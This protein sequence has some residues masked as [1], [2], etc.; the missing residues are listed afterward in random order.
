MNE[1][2]S[3]LSNAYDLQKEKISTL[4]D[5]IKD[6]LSAETKSN[7]ATQK[8]IS[9]V[10]QA[11]SSW[12]I[13][14]GKLNIVLGSYNKLTSVAKAATGAVVAS[15]SKIGSVMTVAFGTVLGTALNGA[16]GS[17]QGFVQSG[18][19]AYTS[20]ERLNASLK[21]LVA[22]EYRTKDPTLSMTDALSKA[23]VESEKLIGW[24]QQLA[25]DSPFSQEGV[26]NAF[27]MAKALGFNIDESKRLT[28]T[29]VD[30][31]SA[32]GKSE[33]AMQRIALALGQIHA[34]GKLAGGEMMQLT[35]A[36]LP[37]TEILA[38]AFHK[39]TQQI[40]QMQEDGL[41]PAQDAIA[42]LADSLDNDFGG[43]AKRQ[44][45]T[46]TGLLNSLQDLTTVNIREFFT[47]TFEAIQPYLIDFV[48]LM[49]DPGITASIKEIGNAMGSVLGAAMGFL[50]NTAIPGLIEGFQMITPAI[51]EALAYII[52]FS[53]DAYSWGSDLMDQYGNGII[54]AAGAVLD[55]IMSIASTIMNWMMPNS[56]PKFLPHIDDW[57][58]E[59]AQLYFDS[60]GDADFKAIDD[61]GKRVEDALS[62]MKASGDLGKDFN[63]ASAVLGSREAMIAATMEF[64]RFGSVTQSTLQRIRNTGGPVGDMMADYAKSLFQA[65]AASEQ[66]DRAQENLNKVTGQYDE[67]L[68]AIDNR[69]KALQG[70]QDDKTADKRIAAIKHQMENAA[71]LPANLRPD[72]EKLQNELEQLQLEKDR[73]AVE[74][75]KNTAVAIAQVQVDAAQKNS[76]I[77]N[78][79]LE[80]RKNLLDAQQSQIDLIKQ[81]IELQK[82]LEKK[83]DSKSKSDDKERKKAEAAAKKEAAEAKR[84]EEAQFASQMASA[85]AAEGVQLL[86]DKL[87]TLTPGTEEYYKV[88]KQLTQQQEKAAKEAERN[89]KEEDK[90]VKDEQKA[91]D[92]E[93]AD[94]DKI[95]DA[96][97]EANFAAKDRVGQI[98]MLK[99][100]LGGLHEGTKEYYDTLKKLNSL[101]KAEAKSDAA[102]G[103]K[104]KKGKDGTPDAGSLYKN[105]IGKVIDDASKMSD[106]IITIGER[107]K[108]F[109]EPVNARAKEFGSVFGMVKEKFGAA[110][111]IIDKFS[112]ILGALGGTLTVILVHQFWA[113]ILVW[114]ERLKP[115]LAIFQAILSPVGLLV[116]AVAL[117]G[118]AWATNFGGIRDIAANVWEKVGPIFDDLMFYI[119]RIVD[120]FKNGGIETGFERLFAYLPLIGSKIGSILGE[121]ITGIGKFFGSEDMKILIKNIAIMLEKIGLW[122]LTTGIPLLLRIFGGLWGAIAAA[123]ITYGPTIM[124]AVAKLVG[125]L[126]TT[127]QTNAAKQGPKI[128]K[129]VQ[130]WLKGIGDAIKRNLPFVRVAVTALLVGLV[131]LIVRGI[132]TVAPY[133]QDAAL[134]LLKWLIPAIPD[135]VSELMTMVMGIGLWLIN[136][137]VPMIGTFIGNTL[138][139]T[140]NGL[141]AILPE[142]G[143]NI[144][145]LLGSTLTKVIVLA[146][147]LILNLPYWIGALGT[148]LW[149]SF[150]PALGNLL[151]AIWKGAIGLVLGI[152]IGI[153]EPIQQAASAAMTDIGKKVMESLGMGIDD[154]TALWLNALIGAFNDAYTWVKEFLGIEG[155]G[156]PSQKF[157]EI[158]AGIV[159]GL[160]DGWDSL[161]KI[162]D[163]EIK[164]F[165]DGLIAIFGLSTVQIVAQII[166]LYF[167]AVDWWEKI[168]TDAFN[169]AVAFV[170]SILK[171]WEQ[172]KLD[173]MKILLDLWDG[174]VGVNGWITKIKLDAI[175]IVLALVG[176]LTGNGGSFP[177]LKEKALQIIKDMW[178][179]FVGASGWITKIKT[180]GSKLVDDLKTGALRTLNDFLSGIKK[181][182]SD[183]WD[184]LMG[185]DGWITKITRDFPRKLGEMISSAKDRLDEFPKWLGN[186][187]SGFARDVYSATLQ[188]GDML[189]QAIKD[190]IA[191]G[192]E[193]LKNWFRNKFNTWFSN[194]WDSSKS[195]AESE[196]SD[197]GSASGA[198][199]GTNY[200]TGGRMWVGEDGPE[201][202][203][204]PRGSKVTTSTKSAL[205]FNNI[206]KSMASH[207]DAVMAATMESV[208]RMQSRA[209]HQ[210]GGAASQFVTNNH[211]SDSNQV[212][213]QTTYERHDHWNLTVN[214][215][216]EKEDLVQDY[217]T[218]MALAGT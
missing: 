89:A 38:K 175:A 180:D 34:K 139:K 7:S 40:I 106:K 142:L 8:S 143:L 148:W 56:P 172:F 203:D 44:A 63:V 112:G 24:T 165:I 210:M 35:E 166:S 81:E 137:G 205:Y 132:T 183:A 99:E 45:N 54:D 217:H 199:V 159:S 214:S 213:N 66:L 160:K 12:S 135:I 105:P 128:V 116:I 42:A 146:I 147:D 208:G 94:N 76:D 155:T 173:T 91:R 153:W 9:V 197:S 18:L 119:G 60:F 53:Q 176:V 43:A 206:A 109:F 39:T 149:N 145:R 58:R 5:K 57:G 198:A 164:L 123:A 110:N 125:S 28:V 167:Q 186:A 25:V 141:S 184:G 168:K 51:Q 16:A 156:G 19:D 134:S 144:G 73:K 77:A 75:Q 102:A 200:A 187:A 21:Q 178:D 154:N 29:L 108:T 207:M 169:I 209:E 126:G 49:S 202:L 74:A 218:M 68:A 193:E 78:S 182:G 171:T 191:S 117:L 150:L 80:M 161:I 87:A 107:L 84:V 196:S 64:R 2:Q 124:A 15:T 195:D 113:Q 70:K 138:T 72:T 46:M 201:L 215:R 1:T 86:Q 188:V 170:S 62:G 122:M 97:W 152:F 17:V 10:S 36:G 55:A 115:L 23:G 204:L 140:M 162:V 37:A 174:F 151:I 133:L 52:G 157:N 30:W 50:A 190:A 82:E 65:T 98:E 3:R 121:I 4:K 189:L 100:K 88:Q 101:E 14:G 32:T 158:G 129:S 120:G 6:K 67:K 93:L 90:R 92:K 13:F 216:A 177:V 85:T 83:D 185:E 27:Q 26:A 95:T 163:N 33:D 59:T 11:G 41:I 194:W 136:V 211:R 111:G 48:A 31:A 71:K 69:M 79:E 103:K 192:W 114:A 130:D 212:D 181:F 127:I 96:E 20:F 61:V 22:T 47:G 131:D 179:G 118:A 104:K